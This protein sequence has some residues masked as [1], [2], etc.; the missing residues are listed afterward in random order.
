[1]ELSVKVRRIFDL[2]L[3]NYKKIQ[4]LAKNSAIKCVFLPF[5]KLF[6]PLRSIWQRV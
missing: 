2:R 6:V 4:K 1:M 3:Q 5:E